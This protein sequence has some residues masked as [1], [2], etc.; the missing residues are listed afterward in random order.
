[1][2][3]IVDSGTVNANQCLGKKEAKTSTVTSAGAYPGGGGGG[4]DLRG[5]DDPPPPPRFSS[6][7][8]RAYAVPISWYLHAAWSHACRCNPP[9]PPPA[10]APE[11]C[12]P[13]IRT[14]LF[15]IHSHVL[16]Q[17]V[18]TRTKEHSTLASALPKNSE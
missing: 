12:D 17:V 16:L 15:T 8:A 3:D 9:P 14:K 18:D 4:G 1:M 11:F 13:I 2:D 6:R 5:A 10:Y 7:T